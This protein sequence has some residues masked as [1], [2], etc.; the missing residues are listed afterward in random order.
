MGKRR[1]HDTGMRDSL[2]ENIPKRIVENIDSHEQFLKNSTAVRYSPAPI[3]TWSRFSPHNAL[4]NFMT[5]SDQGSQA[6][7]PPSLFLFAFAVGVAWF[8]HC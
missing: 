8:G 3:K 5:C 6:G 4:K 1:L 7:K 2:V